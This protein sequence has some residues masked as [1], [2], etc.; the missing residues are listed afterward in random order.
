[1]SDSWTKI[2][3]CLQDGAYTKKKKNHVS[4]SYDKFRK[5]LTIQ[6]SLVGGIL[7]W[8]LYIRV[9][10][11]T[12]VNET[13]SSLVNRDIHELFTVTIVMFKYCLIG[14]VVTAKVV[15]IDQVKSK[16]VCVSDYVH[17]HGFFG[18]GWVGECVWNSVKVLMK[19]GVLSGHEGSSDGNQCSLL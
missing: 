1:M 10:H 6:T 5:L 17:T 16:C 4:T 7:T 2:P 15:M 12:L 11:L 9:L 3:A 8:I 14:E 19:V 18:G 13:S